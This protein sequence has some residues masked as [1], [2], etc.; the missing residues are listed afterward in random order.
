MGSRGWPTQ[1][2]CAPGPNDLQAR[3][4]EHRGNISSR[5]LPHHRY[6]SRWACLSVRTTATAKRNASQVYPCERRASTREHAMG[7]GSLGR[8]KGYVL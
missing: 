6:A 2:S 7:T 4:M 1:A 5:L 3:D 8:R